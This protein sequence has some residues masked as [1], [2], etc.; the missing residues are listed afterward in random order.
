MPFENIISPTNVAV[1]GASARI[2]SVGNAVMTNIISGGN[3]GKIYPVN[4]S[5][6]TVLGLKCYRSMT[7]IKDPVGLAIIITPSST[8]PSIMEECGKKGVKTTVIISA[9]FKETGE[10]GKIFEDKVK[11][12]AKDYGI[13]IIGPNCIGIINTEPKVSLNASFTKSMPKNGNIAL[14]SQ[15]GAICVAMLECAKTRGINFSSI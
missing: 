5:S 9:G 8:V 4:P 13:R 11:A 7:D 3:A 15:S 1:L 6:D 12:I 14:V 10:Q 2:G